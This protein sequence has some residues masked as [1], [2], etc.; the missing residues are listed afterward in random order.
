M[1]PLDRQ[2]AYRERYKRLNPG[3][4]PSGDHFEALTR[5]R[6]RP[7]SRVLDLGCGRGGVMELFW[8]EARLAVGLDPDL[9]SLRE[10]RAG[11]PRVCGRGE[12]LPF[13]N[14]RFDL[15]IGLWLLEHLA[16]PARVLAE[17]AR[18]LA[19]GGHFLFLTPNAR[20]PLLLFN[21]FSWAFPAVQRVLV[22]R[23]YGRS[24]GDTFRVHYRANT[25]ARLRAL[26]AGAGLRVERLDALSDP[27]YL[28]FNPLLFRFAVWLEHRL[29]P[30]ARVHL[31]GD[32]VR[33]PAP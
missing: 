30:A 7:A 6:L 12:A 9:A 32:L 3:W 20:H 33:P 27:T 28:A 13:A 10:H 17:V 18:V 22:P 1:L 11:L 29:P 4:R 16:D 26:A 2:N 21:R 14:Q 31:L 5:Q 24:E 15:V 23:L 8:R 25:P 19:P